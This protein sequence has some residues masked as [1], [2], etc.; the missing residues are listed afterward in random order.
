MLQKGGHAERLLRVSD[1]LNSVRYTR[2]SG[3]PDHTDG[4]PIEGIAPGATCS[5]CGRSWP[6]PRRALLSAVRARMGTCTVLIAESA[7]Y[8]TSPPIA[9]PT[10]I[11]ADSTSIRDVVAERPCDKDPRFDGG[12]SACRASITLACGSES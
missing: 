10:I 3:R 1:R 4:A 6:A 8:V 5:S 11:W 9:L 7:P 2:S 12:P